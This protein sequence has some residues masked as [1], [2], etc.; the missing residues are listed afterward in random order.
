MAVLKRAWNRP[1]VSKRVVAGVV[2]VAALTL[3]S[4][5]PKDADAAA[6]L[7]QT[8]DHYLAP[9]FE[10]EIGSGP[11]WQFSDFFFGAL[12]GDGS[13]DQLLVT[14]SGGTQ[15]AELRFTLLEP[16]NAVAAGFSRVLELNFAVDRL[17]DT[18][19]RSVALH[20]PPIFVA[21]PPLSS[22]AV[23][24]MMFCI[25]NRFV[26]PGPNCEDPPGFETLLAARSGFGDAH[27][28]SPFFTSPA[29]LVDTHTVITLLGGEE[30]PGGA[31]IDSIV[32][33]FNTNI[34][35][36]PASL[37]LFTICFA[38]LAFSRCRKR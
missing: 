36:E 21:G 6:C 23:V 3:I 20:V 25:D 2:A 35:P 5:W 30:L 27:D 12:L 16:M 38:G 32:M 29:Y 19:I 1:R 8:L 31:R 15:R 34:V 33:S 10:C 9:G 24:E 37:G 11:A 28:P 13:A 7:E 18:E 22:A 4:T 14:P 17:L 26:S